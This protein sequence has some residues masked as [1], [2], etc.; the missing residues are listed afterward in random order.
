MPLKYL[1]KE[2]RVFVKDMDTWELFRMDGIDREK[3]FKIENS[4]S[5]VRIESQSSV[6]SEFEAK[7]EVLELLRE[8]EA[9]RRSAGKIGTGPL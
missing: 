8:E 1:E 6:I 5:R 2:D 9:E 4:D 7:K 3:W